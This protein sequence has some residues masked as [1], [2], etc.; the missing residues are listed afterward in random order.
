MFAHFSGVEGAWGRAM[1]MCTEHPV[2]ALISIRFKCAFNKSI[3]SHETRL[4]F[5]CNVGSRNRGLMMTASLKLYALRILKPA[6]SVSSQSYDILEDPL[7]VVNTEGEQNL[8]WGQA[9][10]IAS[11]SA[12]AE[13]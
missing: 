10:L 9:Y 12:S 2:R 7:S 5:S 11:A 1:N 8:S 3:P 13:Q 6:E 4:E